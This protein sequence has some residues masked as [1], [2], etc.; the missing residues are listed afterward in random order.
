MTPADIKTI[1]T[2]LGL[3]QTDFAAFVGVKSRETVRR[4]ETGKVP[5]PH[6]L[7]GMLEKGKTRSGLP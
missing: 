5:I 6:W 4:W 1:R 7:P 2:R 3:N